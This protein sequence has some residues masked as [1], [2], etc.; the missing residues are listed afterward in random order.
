MVAIVGLAG[1]SVCSAVLPGEISG[2]KPAIKVATVAQ[3]DVPDTYLLDGQILQKTRQK[4]LANDPTLAVAIT[5]LRSDAERAFREKL[6]AV[7]DKLIPSPSGNPHDY[8]SLSPF[9][10]PNPKS[11]DGLPYVLRDGE[12]NPESR[13]YDSAQ[14]KTMCNNVKICAL[15]YYLTGD[16]RY[17]EHAASQIRRWFLNPETRMSP[18]LKYGQLIKGKREGSRWGIIDTGMLVWVVEADGLLHTFPGWSAKD[19][20]ELQKWFADYLVWLETSDL[21]KEESNARNNHGSYYDL[22]IVDFALFTGQRKLA[23]DVLE[24]AKARRLARQIEPDGSQPEELVRTKSYE[25]CLVNLN[26]LFQLALL[27]DR[28]G[29]DLWHYRSADGC[30]LRGALDWMIP[31]TTGA[32]AWTHQQIISHPSNSTM[33]LLLRLAGIAYQAPSYEKAILQVQGRGDEV[34]FADLLYPVQKASIRVAEIERERILKLAN[35]ALSMKPPT[36]TDSI[37]TNSLG[38]LHDYYSQADYAWPNPEKPDGRPYVIRDGESNPNTFTA[39]RLALR[40]MK[41]GVAALAAAYALT[42]DEKYV[43]KSRELLSVFFLN[44]QTRMNPNLQFAQVV[45]GDSAGTPYGIID[46]L[47]LAEVAIAIPFLEKSP[48]FPPSVAQGLKQWFGDYTRWITTATNGVS[49]MNSLNNHSIACWVQLA[50]FAT[51]TRDFELLGQAR[52]RFKGVLFPGQ[53]S[54]NGSFARELARTKPYGYSIFQAD[55]IATLCV[56]LS[57]PNEDF[58]QFT[59]PDGRTPRRAVDFIYPYLADKTQWVIDGRHRDIMHWESWPVRQ[60][61]LV[62]AWAEFGDQKYC[63]LWRKLEADPIDLEVCRNLAITQPLLWL[64]KPD[65]I[66]LLKQSNKTLTL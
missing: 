49:E 61:C 57:S 15:A 28:V 53:M 21:G 24:T 39:H 9:F 33:F 65:E 34:L 19:H 25:Y 10:W 16:Q 50:S 46:T 3:Q 11:A 56:L 5:K 35:V 12:T 22:Q 7:T 51:L 45:L 63:D 6:V 47:H 42:G 55:N 30:S 17:A 36:I 40:K 66:P 20:Q 23:A 29:V 62:F 52:R 37:A 32:R 2:T 18:H 14:L 26:A 38:G 58:W 8:V 41:T 48:S 64:A 31:Y 1:I 54:T 43:E 59:L 60:S 44:E 27:G 4:V 13:A